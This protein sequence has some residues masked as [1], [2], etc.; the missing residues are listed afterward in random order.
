LTGADRPATLPDE[1]YSYDANGNRTNA[2]YTTRQ[3]NRLRSDGTYT[4]RYDN[5]GN[6]ISQIG[7]G[8][9]REFT[10]DYRNRLTRVLDKNASGIATKSVEYTYDALNQR[11][12]KAADPDG[13]GAQA[14]TVTRFI[15]DRDHVAMEFTG[16]TTTRYLCTEVDQILAMDKASQTTWLLTDHLGSVRQGVNNVGT[17]TG[18]LE[19]NSFGQVVSQT[20]AVSDWR[21]RYTGR[22][23][24]GETGLYYYRARYYDAGVG[25]FIGQDPIGFAAGDAN[26]YRYVGNRPTQFIDPSGLRTEIYIHE[27][28]NWYGH[29]AINVNGLVYTFG[30][31]D[32]TRPSRGTGGAIGEGY[33]YITKEDYYL[34]S[35]IFTNSEDQV[36]RYSLNL[37][38]REEQEISKYFQNI[39][40]GG[41]KPKTDK[42]F[43]RQ[44]HSSKAH[45]RILKDN[46]NFLLNNCTTIIIDSL[47][48]R[49]R[50]AFVKSLRGSS[51]PININ[52]PLLRIADFE[53]AK[54]SP[55][56]LK[57]F[58]D[59]RDDSIPNSLLKKIKTIP[60]GKRLY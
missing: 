25:R 13:A 48:T 38:S 14:P 43:E 22:E 46:Y 54:F 7:A 57:K 27:G 36:H 58:L 50:K 35:K 26:L 45:G 55:P 52:E 44:D 11:I 23:F 16:S 28:K 31:Y 10:W 37:T 41:T 34:K 39:F 24:D 49:V 32:G 6:L 20:G 56:D 53:R 3:D 42:Y 29:T 18:S 12:A 4:Y 8:L 9:T 15:Y 51:I 21:Y 19:Y 17:V 47:P 30:R 1:A 40:D 60:Q 5:E 59:D 33:M 2:G